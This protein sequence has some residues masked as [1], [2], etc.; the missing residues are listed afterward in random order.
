MFLIVNKENRDNR[1]IFS[2]YI[3][4]NGTQILNSEKYKINLKKHNFLVL[5]ALSTIG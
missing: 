2:E 1:Y 5:L 4:N 3:N